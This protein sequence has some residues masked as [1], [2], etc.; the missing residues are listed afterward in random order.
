MSEFSEPVKA[1]TR[2]V[3]GMLCAGPGDGFINV[4]GQYRS[5]KGAEA[6]LAVVQ[7]A[8]PIIYRTARVY[9]I[10]H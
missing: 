2:F 4:Y 3:V 10:A 8:H 5:R 1:S 7:R 9:E 6:K